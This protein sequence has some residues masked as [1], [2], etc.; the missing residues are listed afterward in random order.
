MSQRIR[1]ENS[2]IQ[3]NAFGLKE[4]SQMINRFVLRKISKPKPEQNIGRIAGVLALNEDVELVV[5]FFDEI[6][7]FNKAEFEAQLELLDDE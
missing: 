5:K 2:T 6:S 4:A 1:P 3:K 7:Q